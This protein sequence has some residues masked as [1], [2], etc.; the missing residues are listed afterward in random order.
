MKNLKYFFALL[1]LVVLLFPLAVDK[2]YEGIIEEQRLVLKD[3][4]IDSDINFKEG[5]LK[6]YR[7][8]DLEI[9]NGR[10]FA[11]S[12]LNELKIVFPENKDRLDILF[13]ESSIDWDDVFKGSKFKARIYLSS[14]FIEEPTVVISLKQFS[15]KIMQEIQSDTTSSRFILPLLDKDV[16]TANINFNI[17]KKKIESVVFNDIDED[18][19][20]INK[21]LDMNIEMYKPSY[22]TND[23]NVDN[24]TLE[25][26]FIKTKEN[27]T[28]GTLRLDNVAFVYSYMDTY[29]QEYDFSIDNVLLLVDDINEQRDFRFETK[30]INVK[31]TIELLDYKINYKNNLNTDETI[32][33]AH[34]LS[35][36][37]DKFNMSY[38]GDGFNKHALDMIVNNYS[39]QE[40][41]AKKKNYKS[42]IHVWDLINDGFSIKYDL[43]IKNLVTDIF[44]VEDFSFSFDGNILKNTLTESSDPKEM[45]GVINVITRLSVD[46]EAVKEIV[47]LEG[48]FKFLEE[49]ALKKEKN[50]FYNLTIKNSEISM[51]GIGLKDLSHYVGDIFFD[52]NDFRTASIWYDVAKQHGN[53]DVFFRLAYSYHELNQ[54]DKAIANYKECIK[55]TENLDAM[56]NLAIV[57]R[58][59][60]DYKKAILWHKLVYEKDTKYG[61]FSIGYSYDMLDDYTNAEKWYKKSIKEGEPVAMWNLGI[62][63]QYGKG[64]IKKNTNQAFKLFL[65]A[66]RLNYKNAIRAVSEMYKYGIGTTINIEKSQYWKQKLN[67]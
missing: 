56:N 29:K 18:F 14:I 51:N 46:A 21:D 60:K 22:I 44:K 42:E 55:R 61:A 41:S 37:L 32:I 24:Y 36:K 50:Y 67:E 49:L 65:K 5:Y 19:I 27:N 26:F 12:L 53:E 1:L 43:R 3:I 62:I 45:L 6:T 30:N 17:I 8:V 25:R 4:G 10:Y 38:Q 66:A 2:Y 31:N 54:F 52:K 11:T 35:V 58:D 15:N 33:K 40:F 48:D 57:Y 39:R 9:N 28:L 34:G 20:G 16:V 13:Y 7:D 23:I 59:K 47:K 64:K 63:Y